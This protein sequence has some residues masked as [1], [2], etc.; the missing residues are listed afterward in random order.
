MTQAINR[1]LGEHLVVPPSQTAKSEGLIR[2]SLLLVA[3]VGMKVELGPLADLVTMG[4]ERTFVVF[5]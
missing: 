4:G 1:R 5:G 3:A 2:R